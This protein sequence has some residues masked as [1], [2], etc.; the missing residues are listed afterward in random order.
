MLLAVVL[1]HLLPFLA[2]VFAEGRVDHKLLSDGM[3][4]ELPG[5]LVTE[6]LL[7]VM[8]TRVDHLVVVLLQLAVV[9]DDCFRDG[10]HG[11]GA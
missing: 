5:E 9:L 11:C 6:A 1:C 7:V 2:Q 3:A 8:V 10:G 4:G